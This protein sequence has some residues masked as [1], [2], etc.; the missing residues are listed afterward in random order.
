MKAISAALVLVAAIAVPA[1]A[2]GPEDVGEAEAIAQAYE[3]DPAMWLLHDEDTRIYLLGTVHVLPAG[4]RW[5][6]AQIDAIVAEA[7][8]RR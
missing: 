2:Q 8:V 5:R 3:P 4:F 1:G 7:A 6:S